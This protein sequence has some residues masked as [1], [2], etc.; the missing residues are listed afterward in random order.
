[1]KEYSEVIFVDQLKHFRVVASQID[2]TRTNWEKSSAWFADAQREYYSRYGSIYAECR[3]TYG[4]KM[5]GY[6]ARRNRLRSE[7]CV[8]SKTAKTR[9]EIRYE[10][11][12]MAHL[13]GYKYSETTNGEYGRVRPS[14]LF[15]C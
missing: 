14:A 4:D 3:K 9:Q 5:Y 12:S 6:Y 7:Y 11:E 1:M 8:K 13:K 2:K 10:N 15:F